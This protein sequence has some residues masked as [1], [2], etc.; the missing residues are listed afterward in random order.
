MEKHEFTARVGKE[1]EADFEKAN[2]LY[3]ALPEIEKDEFCLLWRFEK[4]TG[5][6]V[7]GYIQQLLE[8]YDK[9][10]QEDPFFE[11]FCEPFHESKVVKKEEVRFVQIATALKAVCD[12]ANEAARLLLCSGDKALNAVCKAIKDNR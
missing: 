9:T 8:R 4:A 1:Y 2:A 10:K 6:S 3:M 7:F 12:S 5:V 11:A